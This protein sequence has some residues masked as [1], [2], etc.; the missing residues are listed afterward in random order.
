[1]MDLLLDLGWWGLIYVLFPTAL[2]ALAGLPLW[3][4]RRVLLGNAVG[5]TVIAV[6]MIAFIL[7]LIF[8]RLADGFF[9]RAELLPVGLLVAAGWVNVL[10]MFFLSGAVEDRVKRRIIKPDDF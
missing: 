7:Q 1:M 6:V 3:L 2:G 9:A 5:S 10:L 8:S 4:R